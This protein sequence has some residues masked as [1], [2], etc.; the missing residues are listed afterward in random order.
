MPDVLEAEGGTRVAMSEVEEFPYLYLWHRQDRKDQPCKVLAR[1]KM[2]SSC[3]QFE[4]GY[5]M[6][7]SR[8]ALRRIAGKYLP[9]S[10]S[11]ESTNPEFRD[12]HAA[13]DRRAEASN[14]AQTPL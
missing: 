2:N 5:K 7:T 10:R 13:R 1:G 9:C 11:P 3:V 12:S 6:I 8:H 14:T 4:D